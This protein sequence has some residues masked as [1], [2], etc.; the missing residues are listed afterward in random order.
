MSRIADMVY[1]STGKITEHKKAAFRYAMVLVV[2]IILI[3][4]QDQVKSACSIQK[5]EYDF[6]SLFT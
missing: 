3:L 6:S 4:L 1:D 5:D 2:I